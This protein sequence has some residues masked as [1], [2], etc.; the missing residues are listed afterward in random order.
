MSVPR[1][2]HPGHSFSQASVAENETLR[3]A[4]EEFRKALA[5]ASREH[6]SLPRIADHLHRVPASHREH[7]VREL[8]AAALFGEVDHE[9][10]I[11]LQD[12]IAGL[13]PEL[14]QLVSDMYA[15]SGDSEGAG[16]G[17]L[18]QPSTSP[19]KDESLAHRST[20]A[21]GTSAA[22][23][24]G[25]SLDNTV[26]LGALQRVHYPRLRVYSG[27][28]G[29]D[30]AP[31]E[32]AVL[33]LVEPLT[34]EQA[35]TL[36]SELTRLVPLGDAHLHPAREISLHTDTVALIS[37]LVELRSLKRW[38]STDHPTWSEIATLM[39]VLAEKL[40]S[41]H[42]R[43]LVHGLVNSTT[44][45]MTRAG[46]P[47]LRDLFPPTIHRLAVTDGRLIPELFHFVPP[48]RLEGKRALPEPTDDIY[49]LGVL[50][51]ELCAG[52]PPFPV[53]SLQ[54]YR[55]LVNDKEAPP[56]RVRNGKVPAE[57]EAI[58]LRCLEIDPARR[59]ESATDLAHALRSFADSSV[60]PA[61]GSASSDR[62]GS[63][64]VTAEL[65]DADTASAS[66]RSQMESSWASVLTDPRRSV[67]SLMVMFAVVVAMVSTLGYLLGRSGAAVAVPE[68]E[69]RE[70]DGALKVLAD[71]RPLDRLAVR[72]LAAPPL[73]DPF[74]LVVENN[75]TGLHAQAPP[76]PPRFLAIHAYRDAKTD[77]EFEATFTQP[78]LYGGFGIFFGAERNADG[79]FELHCWE[80]DSFSGELFAR[81]IT[82]RVSPNGHVPST[83]TYCRLDIPK[84]SRNWVR[85]GVRLERGRLAAFL[86][87]G[88][89]VARAFEDF[90]IQRQLM[91]ASDTYTGVS[92][93]RLQATD[94]HVSDLRINGEP[95]GFEIPQE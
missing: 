52:A 11:R 9:V 3:Q 63:S 50:L 80:I 29:A 38:K 89:P 81:V 39:A 55:A 84:D 78:D 23:S 69:V 87:D 17:V 15:S 60:Q 91:K 20:S 57:L 34:P 36:Q 47:V 58:C 30:R 74:S 66:S 54:Q 16:E 75:G 7:L 25:T 90:T 2:P 35:S 92:G 21:F 70:G 53:H 71:R 61:V 40:S 65:R 13:P 73:E 33:Q 37:P 44:A 27:A 43:G 42:E 48:E 62:T 82:Y 95:Y 49:A 83:H 24:G 4:V 88:Q 79:N 56:L 51:Y 6:R 1:D 28:T 8:A 77:Y 32:V 68:S 5:S 19:T 94:V 46:R 41:L 76:Y 64:A 93:F 86:L 14:A 26:R 67:G 59:F 72:L 12:L 18:D 10:T 31:L 85:L 45:G 22:A